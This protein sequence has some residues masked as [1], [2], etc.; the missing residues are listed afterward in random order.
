MIEISDT[1]REKLISE[2]YDTAKRQL[3]RV[4]KMAGRSHDGAARQFTRHRG[5]DTAGIIE[6]ME[7]A[8]RNGSGRVIR[9]EPFLMIVQ[10]GRK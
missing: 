8:M 4:N 9:D 2:G 6:A 7:A 10:G 1:L 5:G 3:G